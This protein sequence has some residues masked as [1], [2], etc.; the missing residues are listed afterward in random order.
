MDTRFT[1][2]DGDLFRKL[3]WMMLFRL[4]FALLLLGGTIIYGANEDLSYTSRPLVH[5]YWL[6]AW[7]IL[8]SLC[9]SLVFSFFSND[10]VF[11]YVQVVIDTL[12]ATAI[13]FLTGSFASLFTFLY[14]I[15][16]ISASMLLS[17][18]GSMIIAGLCC[19]EYG[20]MVDLEYY[21]IIRPAF[22]P[23]GYLHEHYEWSQVIYKMVTV[24]LACF[25]TLFLSAYLAERERRAQSRLHSMARQVRRMEQMAVVGEMAAGL[26]HE[27]K[28]PLASL[29]GSIQ[30]LRESGPGDG[31]QAKLMTI[32]LREAERLN[33][34]VSDFLQFA[35]PK[36]GKPAIIETRRLIDET[37][38]LFENS[39]GY[40]ER[41][42][43][44]RRLTPDLWTEMDPDQLKQVMLNLLLNAAEALAEQGG[45]ITVTSFLHRDQRLRIKIADDGPGMDEATLA[46][47]FDP[48]F[49][50]KSKGT[51]L[52]LSIVLRILQAYDYGI[53]VKSE[54]NTGSTFTLTLA[55]MPAPV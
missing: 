5:I 47:I 43:I 25:L 10:R 42:R 9:Y 15:V 33:G 32:A 13:I 11:A 39:D 45:T 8:L 21:E 53:D 52:G 14:L 44:V 26:A 35:R 34:L 54:K 12:I 37:L 29:S 46:A 28:N 51:G 19:L 16:I 27:I 38:S 4:L 55:A 36:K 1:P 48:F 31:D 22:Y 41:I 40:K 7:I 18:K 20:I 6:T 30:M 50:T 2:P 17:R 24:M 23:E 49:T 3:K